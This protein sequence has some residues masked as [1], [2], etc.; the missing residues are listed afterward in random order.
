MPDEQTIKLTKHSGGR[1]PKIPKIDKDQLKSLYLDGK[2]DQFVADF[3]KMDVCT[4]HRWKA[5]N[6]KF[7]NAL[8]DWKIEADKKVERSLY[9]RARGYTHDEEQIFCYQGEVVRADTK[10]HYP[11]DPTSMIFWLKNRQPAKWRDK[12]DVEHSGDLILG[13]GHRKPKQS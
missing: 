7:C 8:K 13:Y 10:K 1:P 6:E 3:F 12:V 11:P 9:E 4:L 5:K 2:T